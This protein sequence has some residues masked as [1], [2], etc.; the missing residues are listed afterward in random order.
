MT[1]PQADDK[2]HVPAVEGGDAGRTPKTPA[3][4]SVST[5]R[6][7]GVLARLFLSALLLLVVLG[8]AGYGALIFKDRDPRIRLAADYVE[9][10]LADARSAFD[11]AQTSVAEL[12]G[13]TRP[14]KGSKVTTYRAAPVAQGPEAVKAP[15]LLKAPE[16]VEKTPEPPNA[17]APLARPALSGAETAQFDARIEAANELARKA[18]QAAEAAQAAA[19]AAKA[20]AEAAPRPAASGEAAPAQSGNFTA[21]EMSAALE[22]RLDALGDQLKALA[23]R[24]DAPKNE[25]RAAPEAEAPK[26]SAD[27]PATMV[28]VAFALQRDLEA[29][30]PFADEIAAMTRLGADANALAALAP[31]A[32]KGA[33]TGPQLREAFAPVAK[34]LRAAGA[35]ANGDLA[36]H[37]LQGASKLVKVHPTGQPHP[38]TLDGKLDKIDAALA[39]DD[40]VAAQATFGTLPETVQGD[41]KDFGETLQQRIAA[42]K[43]ANELLHNAIAALGGTK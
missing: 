35:H 19:E 24:L 38:E 4:P 3:E 29:G 37:L 12:M 32:E 13:D 34:R 1:G 39:H 21:D 36:E 2:D 40:F 8:V 6:G 7:G 31:L 28:V 25:T 22:G 9:S 16:R 5:R 42:D 33:P 14:A 23:E 20:A 11:K 43:A 17:S 27:G 26:A 15:E 30:R 10:G 18:L 41:A